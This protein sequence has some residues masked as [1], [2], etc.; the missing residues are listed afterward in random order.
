M[1]RTPPPKPFGHL[2]AFGD[3]NAERVPCVDGIVDT[4][5]EEDESVSEAGCPS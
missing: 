3:S 4:A 5:T 1:P 2:P